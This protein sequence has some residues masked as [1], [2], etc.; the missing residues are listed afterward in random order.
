MYSCSRQIIDDT[1]ECFLSLQHDEGMMLLSLN[2]KIKFSGWAKSLD[3]G[4]GALIFPWLIRDDFNHQIP[5]E[6]GDG[7][8]FTIWPHCAHTTHCMSWWWYFT[9]VMHEAAALIGKYFSQTTSVCLAGSETYFMALP[10]SMAGYIHAARLTD[11][12]H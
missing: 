1:K 7:L 5:E 11:F 2:W 12:P 3:Y 4:T 10:P 9:A 6:E 8:K